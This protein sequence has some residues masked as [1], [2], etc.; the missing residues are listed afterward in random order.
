M[1]VRYSV[2]QELVRKLFAFER[3]DIVA[4]VI[5]VVSSVVANLTSCWSGLCNQA[6][7]AGFIACSRTP[8]ETDRN[9]RGAAE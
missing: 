2:R 5:G 1:T 7:R 8:P 6:G 4:D 9:H 3:A